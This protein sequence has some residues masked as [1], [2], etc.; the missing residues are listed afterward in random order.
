MISFLN[1]INHYANIQLKGYKRG[2]LLSEQKSNRN[3]EQ[4]VQLWS[5]NLENNS[6]DDEK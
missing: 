3:K 5:R 1:Q 4:T 2:I 6:L